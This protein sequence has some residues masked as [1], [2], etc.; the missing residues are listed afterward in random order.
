LEYEGAKS[1]APLDC[2][3]GIAKLPFK[4]SVAA[5]LRTAYW[6]QNQC[7]YERAEEAIT[8]NL[9][10]RINDDTVRLVTNYIGGIVF[11]NDCQR[12]EECY[13]LLQSAKLPYRQCRKG[14][15]Y[16]ETDGAALN[17]RHKNDQGSTWRENK[18][19]VV[20][21]S[22][23]IYS[24]TDRHGE[25]RQQLQRREYTSYI[26]SVDEFKKHLLAC[27]LRNGYGEYK[28]TVV[29]S[30]G[31]AWIRSM[32]EEIFHGA[33]HILDYYHLSENVYTYAKTLF[34][35]DD[36]KYVPWAKKICDALKKSQFKQV[37]MELEPYKDK[38][39]GACPVNL[40]GYITN[41]ITH[42]DYAE[43]ERKGYYIG[44]GAVESGNKI[45]LQQRLKQAGMRW[46]PSSAQALL[47][48]KAKAESSLWHMDVETPAYDYFSRL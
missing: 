3:L 22:D 24:W 12:A 28:E 37:L 17:T 30:D 41:N 20:F 35:M 47:T 31:A 15:L 26:G 48:L 36:S 46:N 38:L 6:A 25:R 10:T 45:V 13:A 42:I 9:R 32:T 4:I 39:S 1:V 29:L 27:A 7:S 33:Q 18:L 34:N 2:Y 19:G 8:E 44:S 5:M 43:Y 16:I 11:K 14:V 23:N 40:Y 21:S